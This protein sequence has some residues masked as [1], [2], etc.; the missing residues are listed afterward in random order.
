MIPTARGPR[1][2]ACREHLR[3]DLTIN[4]FGSRRSA[5]AWMHH[6][7]EGG[8][9]LVT[10]RLVTSPTVVAIVDTSPDTVEILRRVLQ[11]AG[12]TV[13]S[14]FIHDIR[15]GRLDFDA[16]LQQHAPAAIVWDIAVPYQENWRFFQHIKDRFCD[17][18]NF[19]LTTTNV[20]Q[21]AKI[22]GAEQH[23]HEIVGRDDDLLAIVR[24]VK[25][26]IRARPTR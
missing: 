13:V 1:S 12:L 14:G 3:V 11:Q 20:S 23:L 18:C 21:V 5:D 25:E 9:V 10:A 2:H 17:R 24:A 19:V 15:D 6:E 8:P 4:G 26:A 16:F 7:R 22:A